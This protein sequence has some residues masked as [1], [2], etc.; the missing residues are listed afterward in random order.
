MLCHQHQCWVIIQNIPAVVCLFVCLSFARLFYTNDSTG[1]SFPFKLSI[2]MLNLMPS[3]T[4]LPGVSSPCRS[5]TTN[6][7]F[8]ICLQNPG[9]DSKDPADDSELAPSNE[10]VSGSSKNQRP[11]ILWGQRWQRSPLSLTNTHAKGCLGFFRC[12]P[13]GQNYP[14]HFLNYIY[15]RW[16]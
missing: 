16:K 1:F 15:P 11:Y 13:W 6:W 2:K 4:K 3:F 5:L 8:L 12:L 10:K 7:T 9:C 14:I